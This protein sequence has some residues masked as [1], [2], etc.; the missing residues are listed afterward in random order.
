APTMYKKIYGNEEGEMDMSQFQ[1]ILEDLNKQNM[2]MFKEIACKNAYEEAIVEAIITKGENITEEQLLDG[3]R[4]KIDE[5]IKEEYGTL[6]SKIEVLTNRS[7][8][9]LE[10]IFH[11][12]FEQ[13]LNLVELDIPT[14]LV[15][16]AGSGKNHTLEQVAESLDLDFYF[17]NAITQEHKLTGFIDANGRFHETQF[18]EAFTNGGLFFLD[19]MDA[20]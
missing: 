2:E 20:S 17:S 19:E 14:L 10:G 13:I 7:R 3:V 11:E 18:Y 1:T 15:G 9:E 8:V 12:K 16:P 4:S 5:Y 6:P